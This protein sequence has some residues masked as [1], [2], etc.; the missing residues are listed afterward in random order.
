MYKSNNKSHGIRHVTDGVE[1]N[2]V[3]HE[4]PLQV[5]SEKIVDLNPNII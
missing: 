2:Y 1:V 3:P 4:P 5:R